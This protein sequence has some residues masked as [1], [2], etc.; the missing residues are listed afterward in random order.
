MAS[1][2]E[3]IMGRAS[4]SYDPDPYDELRRAQ[5]RAMLGSLRNSV[6]PKCDSGPDTG[7][8]KEETTNENLLLLEE[9]R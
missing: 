6:E 8:E 3:H 7:T 9:V 1:I 2:P 5:T 4:D